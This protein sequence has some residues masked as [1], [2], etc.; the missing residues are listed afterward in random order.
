MAQFP[1][2][3]NNR[4]S[5]SVIEA[6]NYALSGPSGLGQS[7]AG[8]SDSY[9]A[10][11]RGTVRLPAVVAGYTTAAH[12][13]SGVASITVASP[14]SVRQ[15]DPDV[16]SKI[17]VGQYVY[18]TNIAVGAQVADTYDPAT[19]PWTVPLTIANTGAV[20]GAVSFYNQAPPVLYVAPI[21]IATIDWIDARTIQV[22]FTT[23]QPTPPFELGSLPQISGSS[24]YN[25]IPQPGVVECTESY[26][27]LQ[28][29]GDI[30][31][32]GTA[33]GGTIKLSNTIQPPVVG[34]SPGFPGAIYFNSTD[35]RGQVIVNGN[36]ADVFIA[37]QIDNTITYTATAV[38]DLEYTVAV[39]RYVGTI[40]TDLTQG[41][42]QYYYD[43]TIASQSYIYPS[44]AIGTATLPMISTVFAN[45]EDSPDSNLYL[46]RLD[47]VFRVINDS[48]AA[49]VT[50]SKLGNRSMSVQVV[51]Q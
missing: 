47:L 22:N 43:A 17:V 46:Y 23:A 36:L 33:T 11:L 29:S 8:F 39:N 10:W 5:E 28:R 26:V 4:D 31:D 15:N 49:E 25:G 34:V 40:P 7:F 27:I 42:I 32:Q 16:P 19:E 38:T 24:N 30:V 48:G 18:G 44:L 51:K 2:E 41:L 45:I 35:A 6:I 9:P 12:G 21:N 37:A 13:A 20:Q 1:L 3:F 14:G 50:S